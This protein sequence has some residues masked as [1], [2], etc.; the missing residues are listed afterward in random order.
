[1]ISELSDLPDPEPPTENSDFDEGL[2]TVWS[3]VNADITSTGNEDAAPTHLYPFK[4]GSP[5]TRRLAPKKKKKKRQMSA[6][7][8]NWRQ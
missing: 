3:A 8:K 7:V 5:L 2:K 6:D 1:M 4:G